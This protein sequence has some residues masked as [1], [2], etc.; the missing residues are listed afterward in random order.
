MDTLKQLLRVVLNISDN[1]M[2]VGR[3]KYNQLDRA[4]DAVIRYCSETDWADD[5]EKAAACEMIANY[6]EAMKS[7]GWKLKKATERIHM[8]L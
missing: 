8:N 6:Q 7:G 2:L 3:T 1:S 4:T 5:K